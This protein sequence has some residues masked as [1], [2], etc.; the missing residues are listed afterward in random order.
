M[1]GRLRYLTDRIA[2]TT[3]EITAY[4]RLGYQPPLATT[5]AGR[6]RQTFGN[7]VHRLWQFGEAWILVAVAL[8]PWLLILSIILV[9][10]LWLARR[11]MGR[12]RPAT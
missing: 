10:L 5:F 4:E 9:P 12:L 2:L 8:A 11:R 7:S 1:Q 6:V 3:V